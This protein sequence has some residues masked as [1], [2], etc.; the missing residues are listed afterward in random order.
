MFPRS[1]LPHTS[2]DATDEWVRKMVAS[3][4][5]GVTD[6]IVCLKPDLTPIGK[7]GVWQ[8]EEIGFMLARA[9][10][11]K[12]LAEEALQV[13]LPYYFNERGMSE[14]VADVDPRNTSSLALLQK[15]G[16]I[17]Y[18]FKEK[19][20]QIGDQW[21]DSTFLKLTKERWA[22]IQKGRENTLPASS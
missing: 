12:G 9:H 21:V 19:T 17:V 3:E 4:Q 8:G 14:I 10:W 13:V 18:D 1:T 7:V 22:S 20:F 5:N 2:K 6:F 11:R 16:F 15:L